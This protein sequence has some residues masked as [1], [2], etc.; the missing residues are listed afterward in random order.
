MRR[1]SDGDATDGVEVEAL[2]EYLDAEPLLRIGGA[3]GVDILDQAGGA[4]WEL[5]ASL[6]AG[7]WQERP[8]AAEALQHRFWSEQLTL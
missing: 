3:G 7:P 2:R 4:G 8:S 5:L 1:D 6:L